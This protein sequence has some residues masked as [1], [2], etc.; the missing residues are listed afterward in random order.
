MILKRRPDID[1]FLAAP[2]P[3]FRAA[4]IH[5]PEAGVARE[6]AARLAAAATARPDDPFDVALIAAADL[7]DEGSLEAEL[8]AISMMGGRRLVRLRLDGDRPQAEA[9]AAKALE[10]HLAGAFNPEAFFLI[11][12]GALKPASALRR[13]AERAEG[14]AVI[15]CYADEPGD[16]ARLTREALAAEGA[17]L[18]AEALELFV[19]RMPQDR[20][21]IRQEIERLVLFLGPG[22]ARPATAAELDGFLGVEPE[23]S[24][25]QAAIDA[26]GGR[27]GEAC[28]NLRRAAQ[29]G[30]SGPAAVRAVGAHLARLR[31]MRGLAEGGAG[32]AEAAKASGVFWKNEREFIRQARAWGEKDLDRV[33]AATL[34]ADKA[35]KTAGAPDDL[36][37]QR[38][39][40]TIASHARRLGL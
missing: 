23:A 35:C 27:T 33:Q 40:L 1:R 8:M 26:F 3:A 36:L 28:A 32:L 2:G 10:G 9:L 16:V 18:S 21:V 15:A 5:G 29:E 38:L 31:R 25:A 17:H 34:G 11:E 37:A 19:S 7:D 12:A 6:T 4:L 30:E 14:C 39:A 20:G 22:A 13:T 24:L